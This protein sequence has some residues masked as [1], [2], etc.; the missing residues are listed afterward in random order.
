[1]THFDLQLLGTLVTVAET[2]SLSGAAP[3]LFRS[4]S[5]VSEQVRKLE[6]A[7]G[8]SLLI[9][10]KAGSCL[11]PAGKR[12]VEHARKILALSETAYRDM[13]G[14][15]IAG[16]LRLAITDYFRP[17]VLPEILKRL[18]DQFPR[19]HLSVSILKSA[20]IVEEAES[21]A[22]DIGLSMTILNSAQTAEM[23]QDRRVT[24]RREPLRWI[25]EESFRSPPGGELPLVV[26]PD[27]CSL[28]RFIIKSLDSNRIRYAVE[29]SASGIGGLHL[30]LSAGL[31]IACLNDSAIPEGMRIFVSDPELPK[32]PDV[33]FKL[34]L[35]RRGEPKFVSDARDMLVE[36]LG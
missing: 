33:E 21:G 11:T 34:S 1:M 24:L 26:M 10:S 19:L 30:A 36:H 7:C 29:H 16:S 2:G 25:A 5:A 9:R 32:L 20:R 14:S 23:N 18:R 28:Q 3:R 27:T 35:P 8:Q 6:E 31:G 15:E 17:A 12:L 4:Q 22:F 13:H